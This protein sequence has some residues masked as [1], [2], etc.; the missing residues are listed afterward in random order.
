MLKQQTQ[1]L[2]IATISWEKIHEF[3]LN[4]NQL[5]QLGNI[6]ILVISNFQDIK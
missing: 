5:L 3:L 4:K 1:T 6:K 2:P